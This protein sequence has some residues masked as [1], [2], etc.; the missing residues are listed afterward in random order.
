MNKIVKVIRDRRIL[1][2]A[3]EEMLILFEN[4]EGF[5]ATSSYIK[6]VLDKVKNWEDSNE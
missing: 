1:I 3:L 6:S 5:Q 2:A 4:Q